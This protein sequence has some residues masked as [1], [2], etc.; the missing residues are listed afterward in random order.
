[1]KR[2]LIV[3]DNPANL[4]MLQTLLEGEGF[5]V[6]AAENGKEALARALAN[7]PDFIISDILM[8]IMDGYTLCRLCKSDEHLKDIPFMFYTAEYTERKDE[9]LALSVGADRFVLKPQ[10]PEAFMN[11]LKEMQEG[12][13]A[14]RRPAPK[15][16]GEEMEFFRQHNEILFRKLEEKMLDLET[17]NRQ[18]K[19]SE[20][21]YRLSFENVRDIIFLI[22][23]DL[24][25]SSISPSLEKILGYRPADFI[26]LPVHDFIK[27]LT[28]ESF[29]QAIDNMKS[30]LRGEGPRETI[31]RCV[32]AYG[33]IRYG[34]VS[35]SPILRDGRII[36][37]IV[38]ARDVTDRKR[39]EERLQESERRYRGIFESA[40]EGIYQTTPAGAYI[41]VNPAFAE[42]FGFASPEEM[43]RQVKDIGK[44][45]YV[46]PADRERLKAAIADPGYV[47]G[48]EA[49]VRR[50][51]GTPFWISIN[52]HAVRDA[53]GAIV[54][55]EGTNTDITERKKSQQDLLTTAKRLR[56]LLAG[57]VQAISMAV[58]TRDPYTSGHQRRTASL[59]RA[60]AAEM[61]FDADRVD[62]V[63]IVA[64]IHDIGKIAVPAEILSKPSKLS[65][66]EFRMI[67]VHA[68]AGYDILKDVEFPWPVAEVILQ[69]HERM[70]GSGYPHGLS[71]DDILL[72]AR[73]LAVADTVEA[74]ASHRPYRPRL[75]IDHAL[76][77][78]SRNRGTLYDPEVVD[79]CLR[80]FREKNYQVED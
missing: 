44:E 58:E 20:E 72:E 55:L 37:M 65:D 35:G 2:I 49:E 36:G 64:T 78:I 17:A 56:R 42:M 66:L 39:A 31:Y 53:R 16:L 47:K 52:V 23:A 59:A 63:R 60:I 50:R 13:H 26:G 12:G 67:M 45:L 79:V 40:I 6:E 71:G 46:D 61:R 77:E 11:I 22:D 5:A 3:E 8:P 57:T 24:R 1:M 34:E 68:Q 4:Y 7:P 30:V 9:D 18:L 25:I 27:A 76:E 80:L 14:G 48:F 74:M 33:D 21:R 54:R 70:D 51:D 41:S 28:P 38:I 15:P 29:E 32:T 19:I 10:E 69:H 73:V 43:I 75:G 62:F